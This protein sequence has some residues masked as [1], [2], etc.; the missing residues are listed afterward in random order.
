MDADEPDGDDD[1]D[2]HVPAAAALDRG[3][4]PI[5]LRVGCCSS[6]PPLLLLL[7][8][9]IVAPRAEE[10]GLYV[11]AIAQLVAKEQVIVGTVVG[12]DRR[13]F[14]GP[15]HLD[16]IDALMMMMMMMMFP[17]APSSFSGVSSSSKFPRRRRMIEEEQWQ[18]NNRPGPHR[19]DLGRVQQLMPPIEHSVPLTE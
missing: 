2:E 7:R 8:R 1:D 10:T 5:V 18:Y 12:E 13:P 3:P 17:E 15:K 19:N 14:P 6:S 9:N 11:S 4:N 16:V